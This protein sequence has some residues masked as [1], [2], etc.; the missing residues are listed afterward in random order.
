VRNR[1]ALLLVCALLAAPSTAL[2]AAD[3]PRPVRPPAGIRKPVND[4]AILDLGQW[5]LERARDL[6]SPFGATSAPASP[7]PAPSP[8]LPL[9]CGADR[10]ICPIG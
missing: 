4:S 8:R 5:L 9:T 1:P 7:A 6:A 3:P 10:T 2:Y